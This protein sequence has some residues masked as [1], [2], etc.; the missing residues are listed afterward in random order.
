MR[1]RLCRA[2]VLLGVA[3]AATLPALAAPVPSGTTETLKDRTG[4]IPQRKY[5][6]LPGKVVGVLVG[7]VAPMMNQEGRSGPPDALAFSAGGNSYRWVYV[8]VA[9]KPLIQNLRVPTGD[10]GNQSKVY[11]SLSMANAQTVRQWGIDAPCALV[12]VD[13]NDGLGSPA[14]ESFVA[15]GMRRLDGTTAFPAKLPEV[16]DA[17]RERWKAVQGK[18]R[19]EVAD[20]LDAVQRDKLKDRKLT[21]PRETKELVYVTWLPE[22]E[23]LQVRFR[24]TVTDGAYQF[25]EIGPLPPG[26]GPGRRPPPQ[27]RLN[28]RFGTEVT[29][30]YGVMYEITPAG[31]FD[32]T[33]LLPAEAS[34]RDIPPPGVGRPGPV[35]LPIDR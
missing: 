16:L 5:Q 18:Q 17:A 9:D 35:P 15:T 20:A 25:A 22:R 8:P 29:V 4:F 23:R 7:D 33:Y 1:A 19:K 12:E 21:G 13:V 11:P 32:R 28:V 26:P 24:T 6:A 2:A 31:K 27:P 34:T 14:Q 3:V 30:E 10:K